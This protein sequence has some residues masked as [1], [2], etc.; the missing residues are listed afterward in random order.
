MRATKLRLVLGGLALAGVTACDEGLTDVNRNPNAPEVVPIQNVLANG[1]IRAV[2]GNGVGSHGE[3]MMLY[4]T[5]LWPQHLAQPVYNDEDKYTPRAGIPV[6][7]WNNFYASALTDLRDVKLQAEAAGQTNV[8]AVAEIMSVYS[9]MVLTD[10]FGSVPYTEALQLDEGIRFPAFDQQADIYESLVQRLATATGQLTGA[11]LG[12]S[13]ATG[14]VIYGGDLQGWREFGNSLRLRI[15]MRMSGSADRPTDRAAQAAQAFA[16]AWNSDI[17]DRVDDQAELVW[18]GT[19]PSVNPIHSSVILGDRRGDF[20]LSNSLTDRLVQLNDPRLSIYAD[21]AANDGTFRGLPNGT[22]PSD[23]QVAGRTSNAGDYASIGSYFL[24]PDL[25]S[26]LMSY[27]E[28]LFLG[29]EAAVRGWITADPATLYRQA[30]TASLQQYGVPQA[31][32][33]AYLAQP[34]VQYNG[35]QSIQEQKWI[36]LYLA[37]PEAFNEFRRTGLPNLTPAAGSPLPP[38]HFPARMPY[39]PEEAT[40]NQANLPA[41]VNLNDPVWFARINR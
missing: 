4:H 12:A 38:G 5:S 26:V 18:P 35:L 11:Q 10:L 20:R 19:Q 22:V 9:F 17:F 32:I 41:G 13:V 2:G 21:P 23:H 40:L 31:Q 8:W 29:A 39:P 14:D 25:E 15:A 34:G 36:A 3:W 6:A 16:A 33:D 28:V 1:M 37:G 30:I 27:S 24:R 7:I